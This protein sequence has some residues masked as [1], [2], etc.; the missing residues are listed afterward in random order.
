MTGSIP[1]PA[2]GQPLKATWAAAVAE[3]V[4]ALCGMAP[5]GM[6]ARDGVGGMG[7]QPLPANLRERSKASAKPLPWQCKA[8]ADDEGEPFFAVYL[9][10]GSLVCDLAPVAIADIDGISALDGMDDWYTIDAEVAGSAT[11][12][13]VIKEEESEEEGD[14]EEE[15]DEPSLKFS[16]EAAGGESESDDEEIGR[17]AFATVSVVAGE[18]NAPDA[19]R[20]DVQI[21]AGVMIVCTKDMAEQVDEDSVGRTEE[22]NALQIA[23]FHDAELDSGKGLAERLEADPD[24][25]EISGT[26]NSIMLLARKEGK[27]IYVPISGD[28]EDPDTSP[29]ADDPCGH[30]DDGIMPGGGGGGVGGGGVPAGGGDPFGH[31]EHCNHDC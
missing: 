23:H 16:I 26:D 13:L 30:P 1:A 5:A 18:G 7:A 6:L 17:V 28:G 24:T 15:E 12:N 29:T 21:G 25:G 27:L 11:L 4:N 3:R 20:V 19:G 10:A 14:E 22:E 8:M 2:K 9:P 31:S